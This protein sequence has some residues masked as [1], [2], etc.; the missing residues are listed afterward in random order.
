MNRK[1]KTLIAT[2]LLATVVCFVGKMDVYA[3]S[4]VSGSL[5]GV[6]VSGSVVT[7]AS[8]A[9]A[10]TVY[11]MPGGKRIAVAKVHYYDGKDYYN[12]SAT[13]SSTQSGGTS[14]TATKKISYASVVGGQGTHSVAYD[15]YTWNQYTSTGLIPADSKSH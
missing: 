1:M 3:A 7:N 8:S 11:T 9:V 15:P 5:G 10:N 6:T 14:A 4:S 2:V 12:T 13:N